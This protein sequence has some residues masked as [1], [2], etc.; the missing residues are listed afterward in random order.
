[1]NVCGF[2][3]QVSTPAFEQQVQKNSSFG[4]KEYSRVFTLS[5]SEQLLINILSKYDVPI[6]T[7]L[8]QIIHYKL[9]LLRQI[10]LFRLHVRRGFS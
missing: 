9:Y 3:L 2:P 10:F 5:V 1:M 8:A 4:K 7:R 6:G